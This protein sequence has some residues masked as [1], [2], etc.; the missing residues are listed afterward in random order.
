MYN[1]YMTTG[2]EALESPEK[3]T[4]E[5]REERG[6]SGGSMGAVEIVKKGIRVSDGYETV[7]VIPIEGWVIKRDLGASEATRSSYSNE[8]KILQHLAAFPSEAAPKV[9]IGAHEI[10]SEYIR[11]AQGMFLDFGRNVYTAIEVS[12]LMLE[13]Q[14]KLLRAKVA[15]LDV[16]PANYRVILDQQGLPLGIRFF[17]FGNAALADTV[18][19]IEPGFEHLVRGFPPEVVDRAK[20][21]VGEPNVVEQVLSSLSKPKLI[22]A[23]SA[24]VYATGIHLGTL[25]NR[26]NGSSAE[27]ELLNRLVVDMTKEKP[28]DR[29]RIQD[30]WRTL[31]DASH[32]ELVGPCVTE[33]IRKTLLRNGEIPLKW[34]DFATRSQIE[35]L[36]DKE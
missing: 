8:V 25:V 21:T 19:A 10:R 33:A 16:K 5:L 14:I 23:N 22:G 11:G 17:D 30:A 26:V 35:E 15:F 7:G 36:L 18:G 4:L 3:Y 27:K 29:I 20:R 34:Q 28:G 1:L 24:A 13:A 32:P 12:R 2:E 9:E 31:K 6:T